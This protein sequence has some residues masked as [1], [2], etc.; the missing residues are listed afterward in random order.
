MHLVLPHHVYV[1]SMVPANEKD[2]DDHNNKDNG[3]V[4]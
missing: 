4:I 2:N 1:R 3:D